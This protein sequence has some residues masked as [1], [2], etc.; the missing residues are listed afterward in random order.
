MAK[1][2]DV[3]K[4][5]PNTGNFESVDVWICCGMQTYSATFIKDRNESNGHFYLDIRFPKRIFED[6]T[7]HVSHWMYVE[8]PN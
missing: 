1:W 3:N 8:L 6:F 4:E 7:S 5:K 2:I